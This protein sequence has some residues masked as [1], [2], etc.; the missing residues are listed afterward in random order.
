MRKR[1]DFVRLVAEPTCERQGLP[2]SGC[3]L[4][5]RLFPRSGTGGYHDPPTLTTVE[6]LL[7]PRAIMCCQIII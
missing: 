5:N 2:R 1:K 6:R 3:I 7:F 4:N